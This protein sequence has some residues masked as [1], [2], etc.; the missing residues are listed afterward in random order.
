M[1]FHAVSRLVPDPNREER[2]LFRQ[3][4]EKLGIAHRPLWDRAM[5]AM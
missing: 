5:G 3:A 4:E 2:E 1:L